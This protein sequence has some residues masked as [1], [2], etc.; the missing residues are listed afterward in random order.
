[1]TKHRSLRRRRTYLGIRGSRGA[2]PLGETIHLCRMVGR[3]IGGLSGH[4]LAAEGADLWQFLWS[5]AETLGLQGQI[6]RRPVK[7]A[8]PEDYV[9]PLR[10]LSAVLRESGRRRVRTA[11]DRRLAWLTD[12]LALDKNE[13]TVLATLARLA[14]FPSWRS[15]A[16][17]LPSG[18]GSIATLSLMTGVGELTLEDRLAPGAPLVAAGLVEADFSGEITATRFVSR[19]IAFGPVEPD[20]LAQRVTPGAPPSTLAWDDFAHLPGRDLALD[21]VASGQPISVLLHGAPGTGKTEFARAL[22]D[23]LHQ[24][25]LFAGLTDEAGGEPDREERLAHLALLRALT[26]GDTDS[27]IVVDE[28]DDVLSLTEGRLYERNGSKLWINRLVEEPVRPTIWIANDAE[29]LGDTVLRRMHLALRFD[30]PTAPVRERVVT[31]AAAAANLALDAPATA[32]LA[33]LPA[34]PAVLANAVA[35]GRMV[36]GDGDAAVRSASSILDAL[37]Q[38]RPPAFPMPV[39]YDTRFAQADQDLT[40]L[41]ERLVA[42]P[43]RGWSLLLAGPPGTG[44]SAWARHLASQLGIDVEEKRGSDLLGMYVGETEGN[45]ARAFRESADRGAMLLID[46]ADAF[47]FDRKDATRSWETGMVAEML[48]WMEHHP[49]PFVATTN[50]AD[51]LDPATQRRFTLNLEFSSLTPARAAALFTAVFGTPLPTGA[52][53]LEGVTPGDVGV[54]AKRAQLLGE[55]APAVLADWVRA[56]VEARDGGAICTGF[57]LPARQAIIAA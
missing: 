23:R 26:R 30:L 3:V 10:D 55:M 35:V 6:E 17:D 8:E 2:L 46:E 49:A 7:G 36:G 21:L 22:A 12:L 47:L 1:M 25:A 9:D 41:T 13:A 24:R 15:F 53:P 56:E 4:Q 43:A 51:S 28:A 48:R 19:I 57:H 34:S 37:G 11:H 52:Q 50:R 45:I 38:Q 44:K 5:N 42:A 16:A 27:L 54:V 18:S 39:T 20:A 33:A 29:R 32:R 14:I 40:A 31:R